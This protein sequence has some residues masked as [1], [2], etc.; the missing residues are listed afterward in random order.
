LGHGVPLASLGYAK[1]ATPCPNGL[2]RSLHQGDLV[3]GE[4][5]E[6]VDEVVELEE[7]K[8]N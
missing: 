4:S 6:L 2:N 3:V 8:S 7:G 1:T 5:V